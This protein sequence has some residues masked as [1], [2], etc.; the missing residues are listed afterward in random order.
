MLTLSLMKQSTIIGTE[1][2]PFTNKLEFF[3]N[4]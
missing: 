1:N 3:L 4:K 2:Q